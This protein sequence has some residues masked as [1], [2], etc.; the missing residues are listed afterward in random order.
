MKIKLSMKKNNKII[1]LSRK[2]NK[3]Q[4]S[5]ISSGYYK[6][7]FKVRRGETIMSGEKIKLKSILAKLMVLIMTINLLQGMVTL[8]ITAEPSASDHV[9]NFGSVS[10]SGNNEGI[11]IEESVTDYSNGQFKVKLQVDGAEGT[12]EQIGKLDVFLL[13]DRSASMKESRITNAKN[14]AKRFVDKLLQPGKDHVRVGVVSFA[15]NDDGATE[16]TVNHGL[17]TNKEAIKTQIDKIEAVGGTFVDKGFTAVM[18]QFTEHGDQDAK[19]IIILIADGE[20]TYAY[21]R[22]EKKVNNG[23]ELS[24]YELWHHEGSWGKRSLWKKGFGNSQNSYQVAKNYNVNQHI[25]NGFNDGDIGRFVRNTTMTADEIKAANIEIIPVGIDMTEEIEK[26]FMTLVSS[27]GQYYNA[28][29]TASNLDGILQNLHQSITT[30]KVRN[31][32]ITAPVSDKIDFNG[33]INEIQI[34]VI[35]TKTN[36]PIEHNITKEWD[37]TK[38]TITLGNI[39]LKAN[40]RLVVTYLAGLKE[41]WMD[42]SWH[43]VTVDEKTTLKP[44]QA[45]PDGDI[46][47]FKVSEVNDFK[48]VEIVVNKTWTVNPPANL[49]EV[50]VS[51]IKTVGGETTT[52]SEKLIVKKSGNAWTGSKAGLPLYEGGRE[53]KYDIKEDAITNYEPEYTKPNG[54][55]NGKLTFG[56]KN[57]NKEKLQIKVVKKWLG[58]MPDHLEIDVFQVDNPN[59]INSITMSKQS[60]AGTTWEYT[61]ITPV[62]KYDDDGRPLS[63][64]LVEHIDQTKYQADQTEIV[65]GPCGDKFLKGTFTN[66]D[67][68]RQNLKVKKKW[69]NTPENLQEEVLVQL[70]RTTDSNIAPTEVQGQIVKLKKDGNFEGE[71]K[72]LPVYDSMG[73]NAT[74]KK[75]IYSVKEEYDDNQYK[76]EY[77]GDGSVAKP[78]V[79]TNTNIE[80]VKINIT[81]VW[82]GEA[83]AEGATIELYKGASKINKA[84]VKD[85]HTFSTDSIGNEL[86]KYENGKLVVYTVKEVAMPNYNNG[87]PAIATGS[88]ED[89]FHFTNLNTTKDVSVTVTKKWVGKVGDKITLTLSS[90]QLVDGKKVEIT[91]DVRGS[92]KEWKYT[93]SSL[94]KYDDEGR[95]MVYTVK[96]APL[97]NY[98]TSVDNSGLVFTNTYSNKTTT[99]VTVSKI[100]K[101]NLGTKAKVQLLANG[102]EE[103]ELVENGQFQAPQKQIVDLT[104]ANQW[105]HTFQ[106]LRKEDQ[107]GDLIVYTVKE[108]EVD[109]NYTKGDPVQIAANTFTITNTNNEK[110]KVVVNKTWRGEKQDTTIELLANGNPAGKEILLSK[111][112]SQVEFTDLPKYEDKDVTAAAT[113]IVYTVREK[114]QNGQTV[115]L[116]GIEYKV[117]IAAPVLDN[118]G[119]ATINVINISQEKVTVKV[120]KEWE[121][122]VGDS[123]EVVLLERGT[124][125][126]IPGVAPI[127][128]TKDNKE[129]ADHPFSKL[130][131]VLKYD[132]TDGR[133]Y[134]FWMKETKING[135][136][137]AGVNGYVWTVEQVG[138]LGYCY[139]VV[140]TNKEAKDITVNKVW[141]NGETKRPD[142]VQVTLKATVGTDNTDIIDAVLAG[143]ENAPEKAQT[144]SHPHW[145]HV[146]TNLPKYYNNQEVKYSV[147][148]TP[149]ALFDTV[150]TGNADSITVT[151]TFKAE[152]ANVHAKKIW[153]GGTEAEHIELNLT[154]QYRVVG[155]TNESD[156]TNWTGSVAAVKENANTWKYTWKDVPQ[157]D[158]QG[159]AY[160]FRAIETQVPK[161]Y[162]VSYNGLT[163]IN[164][165]FEKTSRKVIK[166]WLGDAKAVNVTLTGTVDGTEVYKS[167]RTISETPDSNRLYQVEFEGLLRY[168]VQRTD[169]STPSGK[170]VQYQLMEESGSGFTLVSGPVWND[171]NKAFLLTNR[172]TENK[173]ITIAKEWKNTPKALI[174]AA[175]V[176]VQLYQQSGNAPEQAFS[177]PITLNEADYDAAHENF[178]KTISVPKFDNQGKTY[179][180]TIKEISI[181]GKTPAEAGYR[182]TENGLTIVNTNDEKVTVEVQKSWQGPKKDVKFTLY[183]GNPDM[184]SATEVEQKTLKADETKL[185]FAPVAKYENGERITY[186]VKEE[187]LDGYEEIAAKKVDSEKPQ[188]SFA[189]KNIETVSIIANKVWVNA[190]AEHQRDVEVTLYVQNLN[191]SQDIVKA[192]PEQKATLKQ[193][194]L[195]HTFTA[196]KYDAD[197][198]VLAYY[199]FETKVADIALDAENQKDNKDNYQ[200]AQEDYELSIVRTV[201]DDKVVV[202]LTNKNIQTTTVKVAK[203]WQDGPA[204]KATVHLVKDGAIIAT[205]EISGD[206]SVLFDEDTNGTPLAKRENGNIIRYT[207]K[208]DAI[209]NYNNDNAVDAQPQNDGSYLFVNR[210]TKTRDITV[211]K[212]WK[213]ANTEVTEVTITLVGKVGEDIVVPEQIATLKA[214]EGWKH[215]FIALKEY[216]NTDKIVYTV[217]EKAIDNYPN[218]VIVDDS[219]NQN[220]NDKNAFTITN[221][222]KNDDTVEISIRKVWKG[223]KMD[224]VTVALLRNGNETGETLVLNQGNNWT[225]KFTGL[226]KM[227]DATATANEY[228][229]KELDIAGF[230]SKKTG[231]M[232]DGFTF[233]NTVEPTIPEHKITLEVEKVF[234]GQAQNSV[235]VQI[236]ANGKP[237]TETLTI[238]KNT[239]GKWI[240]SKELPKYDAN[241]GV[242]NTDIGQIKPIVY[243]VKELDDADMAFDSGNITLGG[244]SYTLKIENPETNKFK[245][246]N[247]SQAKTTILVTKKWVRKIGAKAEF[248]LLLENGNVYTSLV[249]EN[250]SGDTWTGQFD[251]PTFDAVSGDRIAYQEVRESK[252][253]DVEVAN[254]VYTSERTGDLAGG[255]TFTNTNKELKGD[256]RITITKSWEGGHSQ[257]PES[258]TVKLVAL[259]TGGKL[260]LAEVL[261][262]SGYTGETTLT[263]KKADGWTLNVNG[264]PK[265]FNNEE[266]IYSVEEIDVPANFTAR[267]HHQAGVSEKEVVIINTFAS[268]KTEL[269]VR[270][271]WANTPDAEKKTVTVQLYAKT[272]TT[273]E[274]P[275]AG[276]ILE[277]AAPNWSGTFTALDEFNTAGESYSYSVK[278]TLI[279]GQAVDPSQYEVGYTDVSGTVVV[280]NTNV[281]KMTIKVVK[282][283]LGND[284]SPNGA[285]FKLYGNNAVTQ[286][287]LAQN[288]TE[289]AFA[290]EFSKYKNGELVEYSL[291]EEAIEGYKQ[292]GEIKKEVNGN[293]ITFTVT[294]SKVKDIT[295]QKA[296][297]GTVV[298]EVSFGLYREDVQVKKLTLTAADLNNGVWTNTFKDV[299]VYDENGNVIDYV[300]RELNQDGTPVMPIPAGITKAIIGGISYQ[301]VMEVTGDVHKFTNTAL[302]EIEVEKVWKGQTANGATLALYDVANPDVTTIPIQLIKLPL[303]NGEWKTKLEN[304]PT[305]TAAGDKIT[306]TVKEVLVNDANE[307]TQVIA[308]NNIFKIYETKYQLIESTDNGKLIF[309]NVQYLDITMK[310]AWDDKFPMLLRESV[311]FALYSFED[312]TTNFKKLEEFILNGSNGWMQTKTDLPRWVDDKFI[313]YRVVEENING[314]TITLPMDY[315]YPYKHKVFEVTAS[316]S[317]VTATA[318]VTITNGVTEVVQPSD[319]DKRNI[320]VAKFWGTTAE[321]H[322]KEVEVELYMKDEQGNLVSTGK[323]LTLNKDNGWVA[324]FTDLP[325]YANK[326]GA[327]LPSEQLGVEEE[328]SDEGI[329][330]GAPNGE[331]TETTENTEG[332]ETQTESGTPGENPSEGTNVDNGTDSE[333]EVTEEGKVEGDKAEG[334][335]E[336]KV[337]DTNADESEEGSSGQGG[338]GT[339]KVVEE[340]KAPETKQEGTEETDT[341]TGEKK[342]DTPAD[343]ETGEKKEDTPTDTETGEKKEDTPADTETGEKKEDAPTDTQTEDTKT[344]GKEETTVEDEALPLGQP[345]N[346]KVLVEY[347]VFETK[348]GGESIVFTPNINLTDYHFKEYQIKI[349]TEGDNVYI[350]NLHETAIPDSEKVNVHVKKDWT[351]VADRRIEDVE[352]SLYVLENDT[353]V[354]VVKE[355]LILGKANNFEGTFTNLRKKNDAGVELKYYVFETKI[356]A[357]AISFTPAV[358]L[359]AY[360]LNSYNI[361]ITDNGTNQVKVRNYYV[362]EPLI[363]YVPDDDDDDPNGPGDDDDV[364]QGPPQQPEQPKEPKEPEKPVLPSEDTPKETPKVEEPIEEE[365]IPQGK[366]ELPKTSGMASSLFHLLGGSLL[367]LGVV[368][369]R[370]KK[371]K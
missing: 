222:Y 55:A 84:K 54:A 185:T 261:K 28:D 186:Y 351:G 277:L 304:L 246:T 347:F 275:V 195:T 344:E 216:H 170:E 317:D 330:S 178:V 49:T 72:N 318:E 158:S 53:I 256:G 221:T 125:N 346:Q 293:I 133:E 297:V 352:I 79:I 251:V 36:Q 138:Q 336:E 113:P 107:N 139:K 39:E 288:E 114:G 35:N 171:I 180:Y 150:V 183:K 328:L 3:E 359:T 291:V 368:M 280:T 147:T 300:V 324:T 10:G 126:P 274:V 205:K 200:I 210:Y 98:E 51:I 238:T 6:L 86:P 305:H 29:S 24:G 94:R 109:A 370:K 117:E 367:G 130:I 119:N 313:S 190:P 169:G 143:W 283:W 82:K 97:A 182:H 38:R 192:V 106:N 271:D 17:S 27:S 320:R 362:E 296:W 105:K 66:R 199:V 197:S 250:Q 152:K 9:K 48:S 5:D 334:S 33:D 189:N 172:N 358:D 23:N 165:S 231:S 266:V 364:P 163:V 213:P 90:D 202:A 212:I 265:Y 83:L 254:S 225:N 214:G 129:W 16:T 118:S 206:A 46:M 4:V 337:E 239:E 350:K 223:Y 340:D 81:K 63:Y 215:S 255:Y 179:T 333:G 45:S 14:A 276:K 285:S 116:G 194:A 124:D 282:K 217:T 269:A 25:G 306:Y 59:K 322:Q 134:K 101:G 60:Y 193:N 278:E 260:N 140:N 87:N 80:K 281:E 131:S 287:S 41:E 343:T 100:W 207:V 103:I 341:E 326:K 148:E 121:R 65:L 78:F 127:T 184:A 31:G 173:E 88:Q 64:K 267:V 135:Q 294:N 264:L 115:T 224:S 257:V 316:Q 58:E 43:K 218:P 284:A 272:A 252:I 345:A 71:F 153:I 354:K 233:T 32:V 96:E 159:K 187:K 242:T 8:P 348:I 77:S 241:D 111:N 73:A 19:K 235:K 244:H 299:F 144:L 7:I 230:D 314:E 11:V 95:E 295:V 371:H 323:T 203:E 204:A 151:N 240:G 339:V 273:D 311:K 21:K 308:P 329:P 298:D 181:N 219:N 253:D 258:I 211:E 325:K 30:A 327:Y 360:S 156:W 209:T 70:Y 85:N 176:V 154:L 168:D 303:A 290:G 22:E 357:N 201:A 142:S 262:G 366:P 74:G 47:K 2:N 369:K 270:K 123:V 18:N 237:L 92:G 120:R 141:V 164:T 353:L 166:T 349:V 321:E 292:F 20:P 44:T 226:K 365:T 315:T 196:P 108:I 312:G 15:S 145:K 307:V 301:V 157:T 332:T 247:I 26:H 91:K 122:R 161:D 245:I 162:E 89:G 361:F 229:V 198:N 279:D 331:T 363:P 160:E 177:S 1:I 236:L 174:D 248:D 50:P 335:T 75:F 208:E 268:P 68:S 232:E 104:A 220:E 102:L 155:S 40:E 69:V 110:V 263:L 175:Q 338:T 93:F 286:L 191:G 259:G 234:I 342:E 188:V 128:L 243:T 319:P 76:V 310:K 42:K 57:I 149:V 99:E 56:I 136:D 355:P 302:S 227:D 13:I 132:Q 12:T 146:Y 112:Q 249:L 67:K 309:T 137:I 62:R 37:A 52:L 61:L 167:S 356:G 34:S 228:D 289:G